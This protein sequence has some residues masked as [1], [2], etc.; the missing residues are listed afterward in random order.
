MNPFLRD[1]LRPA[2]LAVLCNPAF[3]S[4]LAWLSR[5]KINLQGLLFDTSSK[6]ISPYVKA[7]IFWGLYE[8]REINAVRR[9][10]RRD[11]DVIELGGSVG[12]V[13]AH[14]GTVLQHDRR[15]VTVEANPLLADQLKHAVLLHAP[16]CRLSV[17]SKAVDYGNSL[18][19]PVSFSIK[20]DTTVSQIAELGNRVRSESATL[21]VPT[22]TLHELVCN[23]SIDDYVL[24]ADI[25]GAEIPMLF[26]EAAALA[27]CQQIIIEL[28]HGYWANR[29]WAPRDVAAIMENEHG[30]TL[31]HQNGPV[32]VFAR[33]CA[34]H[35]ATSTLA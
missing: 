3:G 31:E 27:R 17:V 9:F 24:V 4:L 18:N 20:S 29:H 7:L 35:N 13:T 28:H 23:F 11:L 14:I 1:L 16:H 25:E 15:L 19:G 21:Q 22:T 10:M 34:S 8:F 30:F 12:A 32:Y 6:V 33:P 26:S 5:D 2:A